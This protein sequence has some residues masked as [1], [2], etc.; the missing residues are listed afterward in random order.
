[1]SY[2]T[3]SYII[4]KGAALLINGT[5]AVVT[6]PL[7]AT[8][9]TG[10]VTIYNTINVVT[11]TLDATAGTG[12]ELQGSGTLEVEGNGSVK[13]KQLRAIASATSSGGFIQSG[14]TVTIDGGKRVVQLRIIITRFSALTNTANLFR[15]E[16]GTL[17]IRGM[18]T[19]STAGLIFINSDPSSVSVTGGTINAEISTAPATNNYKIAPKAP[20]WNLNLRKTL[21]GSTRLFTLENIT[22]GTTVLV[23]QPLTVL[24]NLQIQSP[25]TLDANGVTVEVQSDFTIENGATYTTDANLTLLSGSANGTLDLGSSARTLNKLTVSKTTAMAGITLAN[26]TTLDVE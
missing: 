19:T 23:A 18:Q 11:G 10:A 3:D 20:F 12:I 6:K 1:M 7:G 14:G 25:A 16:A 5:N 21:T 8:A 13:S 26:V 9:S 22:S 17:T 4:Y 2:S 24:G 15:M